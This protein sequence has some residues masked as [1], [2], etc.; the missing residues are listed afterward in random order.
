MMASFCQQPFQSGESGFFTAFS[1]ETQAGLAVLSA[2]ITVGVF[3]VGGLVKMNLPLSI[4]GV[5]FV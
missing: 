4:Y 5:D 2:S 1:G 3:W